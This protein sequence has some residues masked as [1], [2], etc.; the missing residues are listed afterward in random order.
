[1]SFGARALIRLGALKNNFERIRETANGAKVMAVV[2][3]NAYGHGLQTVA[4][5]LPDADSFAVAR[6]SEA[7]QLHN[8]GTG[9]PIV[10]L[11][12]FLDSGELSGSLHRGFEMVVHCARQVELLERATTGNAIVWLKLDTGMRRLGFEPDRADDLIARLNSCRSVAEVRLMTHLANADDK[13]DDTTS[14]QLAAFRSILRRFDGAFSIANSAGILG[15]PETIAAGHDISRSWVRAGLCLYGVSP[16]PDTTGGDFGLRPAM[17]FSSKLIGVK[18]LCAGEAVG[19]G[20]A[21]KAPAPTTL[22]IVSAGYGDG[23]TRF[24]PSG[25]PVLVDGRRVALAGRVSMDMAAVDLGAGATEEVG[26]P[27][28]LWG[29]R[30]PVE[31]VA[32]CAGTIPYQLLA[33]LTHREPKEILE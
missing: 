30:L 18:A 17:E 27:V 19:Y 4:G 7:L 5:N 14:R 25:T 22:G 1:V 9:K 29:E 16:F 23:Y 12:G 2:K 20:G 11:K 31:E 26:A 32:A 10:L 15:W 3:A 13:E 21:W 6:Y 33:G 24:L 8:V 28:T